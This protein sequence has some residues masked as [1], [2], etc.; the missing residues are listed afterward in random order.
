MLCLVDVFLLS[1]VEYSST[2]LSTCSDFGIAFTE[3]CNISVSIDI[4]RMLITTI[5][6]NVILK[7]CC[8]KKGK[9][10]PYSLPNVGPIADP[11][12]QAV[13]LQVTVSSH[14]KMRNKC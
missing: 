6:L 14:N 5:M 13:N 2:F 7:C 3:C 1:F 8:Y 4:F 12:V 10:F 9:G 11:G